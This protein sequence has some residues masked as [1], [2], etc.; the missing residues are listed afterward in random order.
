MDSIKLSLISIS[1]FISDNDIIIKG[2]VS[3]I[4]IAALTALLLPTISSLSVTHQVVVLA[5][6]GLGI[7]GAGIATVY[8]SLI[9]GKDDV[10]NGR[11]LPTRLSPPKKNK[12]TLSNKVLN[13]KLGTMTRQETIRQE[14][15]GI[16][17]EAQRTNGRN[18]GSVASRVMTMLK[19]SDARTK[20]FMNNVIDKYYKF[21]NPLARQI[22]A[23][24]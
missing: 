23:L 7:L 22:K 8:Y 6:S 18:L 11:N 3:A 14:F 10:T 21:Q 4:A 9:A 2:A 19:T 20:G 17:I 5:A 1:Q 12:N 15:S 16:F 13:K 24:T